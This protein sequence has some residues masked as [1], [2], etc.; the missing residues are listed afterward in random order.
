[1]IDCH[2]YV[3]KFSGGTEKIELNDVDKQR[4]IDRYLQDANNN[5]AETCKE[6]V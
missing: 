3:Q 1:M 2:K 5:I 4:D 6:M